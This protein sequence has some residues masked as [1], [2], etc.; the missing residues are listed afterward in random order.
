[1]DTQFVDLD[2][3][4]L[5]QTLDIDALRTVLRASNQQAAKVNPVR[6]AADAV[7]QRNESQ[8]LD[9]W[10]IPLVASVLILTIAQITKRARWRPALTGAAVVLYV[11]VTGVA[12][13]GS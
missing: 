2:D 3:A 5:P 9:G 6:T 13:V 12:L 4:G 1:L 11:V 7:E 10:T 8:R